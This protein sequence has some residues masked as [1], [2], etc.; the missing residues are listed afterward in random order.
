VY[1]VAPE[2][3]AALEML[4]LMLGEAVSDAE[5]DFGSF[6]RS[7][8]SLGSRALASRLERTPAEDVRGKAVA[9]AGKRQA[10]AAEQCWSS[11]VWIR[12]A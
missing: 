3:L 11:E 8:R 1:D 9:V 5:G 10:E 12:P 2:S 6:Y 4:R 7:A